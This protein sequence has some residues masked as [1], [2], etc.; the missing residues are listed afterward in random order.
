LKF[1]RPLSPGEATHLRG[2]FGA[3]FPGEEKLHHHRPDGSLV[4]DYPRVQ[5]KVIDRTAHLIGL[6][7]GGPLIE[8]LWRE[9]ES[10]RLGHDELPILEAT[11]VRRREPLGECA[12]PVEYRFVNPWLGLNLDN[13]ARYDRARSDAERLALLER[14]PVGNCL[15]LAKAF[16]H[17]V[18]GRLTADARRLRPRTC[19]FKDR[20]MV[21]FEGPF[22]VNFRLPSG[23]GIGKSVNRGFGTRTPCASGTRAR[24][25]ER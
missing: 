18:E 3:A 22:R 21:G 19:R 17:W 12:D 10:A 24:A 15:S 16:G 25:C 2:Y 23:V 7:D 6:S 4:Y 11:L 1:E 8:R 9:V 5:F 13:H 14:V 20:P